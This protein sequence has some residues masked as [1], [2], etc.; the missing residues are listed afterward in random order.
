MSSYCIDEAGG[1]PRI[2]GYLNDTK[3]QIK[4]LEIACKTFPGTAENHRKSIGTNK[5]L[6]SVPLLNSFAVP[7]LLLCALRVN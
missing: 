5:R 2:R 7:T 4:A 3:P 6:L 1:N